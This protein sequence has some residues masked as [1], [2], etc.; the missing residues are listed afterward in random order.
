MK[1]IRCEMCESQDLVK[2]DGYYVCQNCG[3]KYDPEEA[4]KLL[5]EVPV[6]VKTDNSSTQVK[7]P[8]KKKS[9]IWIIAG[10]GIIATLI[11][12]YFIFLSA[13]NTPFSK[14]T[15]CP[16]RE[17]IIKR[18]GEPS[19]QGEKYLSYDSITWLGYNGILDITLAYDR[20]GVADWHYDFKSSDEAEKFQNSISTDFANHLE[21]KS[22]G[23]YSDKKENSYKVV[24]SGNTVGVTCLIKIQRYIK[25]K[26]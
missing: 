26:E 25:L 24:R 22:K 7:P 23:I 4:K 15:D 13:P 9:G 11:I 8:K 2:K 10:F 19:S 16:N 20:A 6:S 5:V 12:C 14:L 21:E 17:T 1:A 18:Y 3:T